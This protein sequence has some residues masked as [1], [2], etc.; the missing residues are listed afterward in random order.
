[1]LSHLIEF[2]PDGIVTVN[3]DQQVIM[4][5]RAAEEMFGYTA[6]EVLGQSLTMLLPERVRAQHQE[7]VHRFNRQYPEIGYKAV[8]SNETQVF[9]GCR[10]DGSCFPCDITVSKTV[11]EGTVLLTAMVRDVTDRVQQERRIQEQEDELQRYKL[12]KRAKLIS[13]VHEVLTMPTAKRS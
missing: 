4:F 13:E 8:R 2:A 10:K 5:N 12:R 9:E 6:E 7:F 11:Y 3:E 1:M